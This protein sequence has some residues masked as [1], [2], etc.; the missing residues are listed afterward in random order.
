M[1]SARIDVGTKSQERED[2]RISLRDLSKLSKGNDSLAARRK[3][4]T[5][6]VGFRLHQTWF[7]RA[8]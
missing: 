4:K 6:E 5:Q 7:S 2:D 8:I 1:R 3:D